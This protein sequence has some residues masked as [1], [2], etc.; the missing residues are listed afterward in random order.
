[1]SESPI[2][3]SVLVLLGSVA[4]LMYG[5]KIMSEGLQKMAGSQLRNLLGAMT[6]NRFTGLL[7]GAFI[8]TSIQ[9]STATT[10]MTVSFV[11]AGVL[12]LRQ[13]ISVIMGANIGTTVTA[14]IMVLG[15]SSNYMTYVVY[16]AI[17]LGIILIYCKKNTLQNM[18][19][20]V[21]GL[22]FMLLGLSTLGANA[23]AMNL[24]EN[25]AV[26]SFFGSLSDMGYGSYFI[27]L[28]L[29][30]LLTFAVQSSAA[31]M[32]ITITLCATGALDIRMGIALVMGENI[33]TTITSNII[34]LNASTQ[35]RRA[36]MAHLLFNVFGVVWV[37]AIFPYFVDFVC[38][39]VGVNPA[40]ASALTDKSVLSTVLAA[41]HSS[42]NVC[43]VLLLIWF[44]KYMEKAVKFIIPD[45]KDEA[46]DDFRLK[47]IGGAVLSTGELSIVAAS[48]EIQ[49]YG[50]RVQRMFGITTNLLDIK[51]DKE[52]SKQYARVEKYESICDNMELEIA[53][54]LNQVSDDHLSS[55]SK[56]MI[57]DMLRQI[58]E[59]ESIGDSCFHVA[60]E[61]NNDRAQK[62]VFTDKQRA[63]IDNMFELTNR[64]LSNM[65]KIISGDKS[66]RTVHDSYNLE[67]EINNYRTQVK[68][69]NVLDVDSG[70]YSY[71]S[72]TK[73]IDIVCECEKLCDYVIN[74]V[75]ICTHADDK[76]AI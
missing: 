4:M 30:G 35:A 60:K 47:F 23:K 11:N 50:E 2:Y 14:W 42:F 3:L 17:L 21:M 70:D 75:D 69:E 16:G 55:E 22:S 54:F 34:A 26:L 38:S 31:I 39:L 67:S 12:S 20:F 29:G 13:A 48:K 40:D 57:R 64:A 7:S 25:E 9:S 10:V 43:N 1:M 45:R 32:A 53:R 65:N 15:G 8:T 6:T 19:E 73:Y 27:F 71:F 5:M 46:A 76:K 28:I 41:F 58:N 63:H 59:I 49:S 62:N 74:V 66:P 61:I 56:M 68:R 24:G 72:G 52:F 37:M 36:A 18:G 44:I 51:E 33:G